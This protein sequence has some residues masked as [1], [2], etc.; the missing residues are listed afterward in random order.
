MR[1]GHH[2]CWKF[3]GPHAMLVLL[4][5]VVCMTVFTASF[6]IMLV[7]EYGICIE[8]GVCGVCALGRSGFSLAD[9][10]GWDWCSVG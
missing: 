7:C 9:W 6:E 5:R 2:F 3:V 10:G 1:Y 4:R 8:L